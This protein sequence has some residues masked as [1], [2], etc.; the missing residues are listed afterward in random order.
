MSEYEINRAGI[1]TRRN[2]AGTV[3]DEPFGPESFDP[4]LTTEGLSRVG[5]GPT[6]RSLLTPDT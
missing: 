3:C 2:Q 5:A 6:I 1:C 4:E